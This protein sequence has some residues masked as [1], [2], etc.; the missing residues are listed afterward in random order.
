[1]LRTNL[2]AY[3]ILPTKM[4]LGKNHEKPSPKSTSQPS[5][6]KLSPHPRVIWTHDGCHWP[7]FSLDSTLCATV[8][9]K[10]EIQ[11][12]WS[13]RTVF[14][15][16]WCFNRALR[17]C[18]SRASEFKKSK[19]KDK[20]QKLKKP[21]IIL[22]TPNHTW[23][24]SY[25]SWD[26]GNNSDILF[27]VVSVT[28]LVKHPITEQQ[29]GFSNHTNADELKSRRVCL[30]TTYNHWPQWQL[31]SSVYSSPTS[32]SCDLQ[33]TEPTTIFGPLDPS[34]SLEATK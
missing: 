14:P 33:R 11:V 13:S 3:R 22:I 30:H 12:G 34:I 21:F 8:G 25:M 26:G 4:E 31:L 2:T 7:E 17:L 20:M 18:T 5:P 24:K 15:E 28:W 23:R 16:S 9:S 29:K 19:G 6:G 32:S 1:M 10:V 27:Q